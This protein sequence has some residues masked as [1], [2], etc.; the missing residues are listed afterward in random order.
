MP[1]TTTNA[2]TSPTR[3]ANDRRAVFL[4]QLFFGVCS[5]GIA[6][7]LGLIVLRL[8]QLPRSA[9]PAAKQLGGPVHAVATPRDEI[10]GELAEETI[11]P[12][13]VAPTPMLENSEESPQRDV[14]RKKPF[15]IIPPSLPEAWTADQLFEQRLRASEDD[16]RGELRA[17]PEL[18]LL[19]DGDVQNVRNAE[20]DAQMP[21]VKAPSVD[22]KTARA[23]LNAAQERLN[24]AYA[25]LKT[26]QAKLA[27]AQHDLQVGRKTADAYTS[28]DLP[29]YEKVVRSYEKVSRNYSEVAERCSPKVIA[30]RSPREQEQIGYDFSLRLHQTLRQAAVQAGLPLQ[31]GP[32][33]QLD[34]TTANEMA[35]ISKDLRDM[36][37]VSV[38]GVPFVARRNNRGGATISG[39]VISPTTGGVVINGNRV[40]ANGE[41]IP[42]GGEGVEDKMQE[43]QFWCDQHGFELKNGTVPTLTQMLQIEDEATRLLLV[44]ELTRSRSDT[45]VT[46]LAMRAIVDLSPAVRQASLASLEQRPS[47][48]YLPVLLRGLRYPW[49][50]VADHAA[51]ALRTLKLQ[52]A[53]ASLVDLLD[54]PSPLA[55]VYDVKTNQYSVREVVRLN[56]LRNC[57][58]CHAPSASK[59]D[60]LVRGIVPTPGQPLPVQYYESQS[61][62]FVRADITFLRQD[63]SVTLPEKAA[64]PWPNE[65]RFDFVTRLRT[66]PLNELAQLPSSAD[67]PQRN[68]V[69][70]ALRGLTGKDGGN[71]SVRW[72]E[73]LGP[74]AVKSKDEKKS[75]EL[76][77]L[78]V[79]PTETD[80]SR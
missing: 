21:V 37:F 35:K 46:E 69:L 31:A 56:H 48:Q 60:G 27:A 42:P 40:F 36:G 23:E 2:H 76:K 10:S 65:Q 55:P 80:R 25:V 53:V 13:Q 62:D 63:F 72:R 75:P 77:K 50:P 41:R 29:A 45:A 26:A 70:Y 66:V 78:G 3:Q 9:Q 73:L 61:G 18:R 7:I 67:Y 15:V 68:A 34:L 30:N 24:A 32:R 14:E 74:I 4:A 17:I 71:S 28:Q 38:P 59:N 20:R 52:E 19:N 54:S 49:T 57:L 79:S 44:R 33:C 22:P 12:F 5:A 58:L 51:V 11:E 1:K 39:G 47:S 43:F 64:A 16:L 6:L 8:A